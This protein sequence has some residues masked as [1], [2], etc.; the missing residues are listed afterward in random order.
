MG[1]KAHGDHVYA[2]KASEEV[3]WFQPEPTVSLQLL[4]KSELSAAT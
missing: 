2:T 3:S 1:R 4:E